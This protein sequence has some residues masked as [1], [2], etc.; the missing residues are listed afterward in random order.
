MGSDGQGDSTY[1]IKNAPSD[2]VEAEELFRVTLSNI[3]DPVFI[4]NRDG[5]FTFAC[6]N[7]SIA[8][9]YTAEELLNETRGVGNILGDDLFRM[10]WT[11]WERFATSSDRSR[12]KT[13]ANA[14]S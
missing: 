2:R 7:T 11:S 8:L 10:I 13:G 5:E 12:P 6:P 4:T 14:I 3:S 9:G 1:L